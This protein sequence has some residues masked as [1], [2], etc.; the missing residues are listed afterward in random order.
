M[1]V[2]LIYTVTENVYIPVLPL[3]LGCIAAAVESR[4][5]QFS[6]FNATD[7]P[8]PLED[9]KEQITAFNPD[10]IGLCARNVDNQD[11]TNPLFLLEPVPSIVKACKTASQAPVVLGGAGFTMFPDQILAFSG[12][13]M[14]IAGQGEESFCILLDRL[15]QNQPLE[16]IPGLVLPN[17]PFSG[18][19]ATVKNLDAWPLPSP[20]KHIIVPAHWDLKTI[21]APIQSR[22]GCALDCSYCSTKN[23]EGRILH[24][25][26]PEL[27][28]RN[29]R[30]FMDKGFT[31][32]FFA[33][34]TF[35]LPPSYAHA[36][37]QALM[38]Y[39][40]GAKWQAIVYPNILDDS[41]AKAMAKAGCTGVSLGFEHGDRDMLRAYNK[42][43]GLEKVREVSDRLKN[44]GIGRGG[45]LLL[46]GPGETKESVKQAF[47]FMKTLNLETVKITS[48]VR[49]YPKT[50]VYE[51]AAA[52][53]V[54]T[55]DQNIMYP[56]FYVEPGLQE[57]LDIAVTD[58]KQAHP[59]WLFF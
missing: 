15:E 9:L 56:T 17:K 47:D 5:H 6:L 28:A 21:M 40:P 43:F 46:G 14:G 55:R 1:K 8:Q 10:V 59:D 54:I 7:D 48:G 26:S 57:W 36:L 20:E 23:I 38:D 22:R 3:G 31:Q 58:F 12:A 24:K 19:L 29:V 42:K 49:I 32:F 44:H 2:L 25:R 30:E 45:F 16:N 37:C 41:L 53:G 35:N 33:D 11:R 13:D 39:A 27:V 52:K 51:Q 50:L 4:G 34:N 18:A